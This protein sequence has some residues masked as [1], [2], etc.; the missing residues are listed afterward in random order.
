MK[1]LVKENPRTLALVSRE[2]VLVFRHFETKNKE[3]RCAIEFLPKGDI[4]LKHYKKLTDREIG[5]FLGFIEVNGDTF[6]CCINGS[7]RVAMPVP[8]E[9]INKIH[10]VDFYSVNNGT[11]D[12]VELD[13]NGFPIMPEQDST[14]GEYGSGS[15]GQYVKHPCQDLRKLLS[16]GG[17]YYSSDFDLTSSL[18]ARGVGSHS[19][20]MD[21]YKEEYMWNSFMLQEMVEFRNRLD[22]Q[23]KEKLDDEG[24]LTTVIRGF[25]K[26]VQTSVEHDKYAM[27]IISRQSWKRAG[28]R[29]NSR[30][31]D[32]EGYVA[33]FVET[34]VILFSKKIC[35]SYTQIRGSIP[36]FWEQDTALINPKVQITRSEEATHPVF[37]THFKRLLEEYNAINI[38]NLLS[39]K[40]SELPLSQR[41]RSHV[42]RMIDDGTSDLYMTDFD[43]HRE[44]SDKGFSSATKIYNLIKESLYEFGYF[45]YEVSS[46]KVLSEQSGSIINADYSK[47]SFWTKEVNKCLNQHDK[48]IMLRAEQMSSLMLL[49]FVRADSMEHIKRVEGANKKTGLGGITGNKG[50]VGIRFNYGSSS[51]CFVNVHLAAGTTNVQDRNNDYQSI[52]NSVKFTRNQTIHDNETV[53]WIGDLNYRIALTSDEV[54]R[55][56]EKGDFEYLMKYDQLTEEIR[57]NRAFAGYSEPSLNFNPTYKYD[58]GTSRYDSSEKF[59][60]P[61]WTDRIIYKSE[62]VKPLAYSSSDGVVFSDHKPVY[63]AYKAKVEFIDEEKKLKLSKDI[64]DK[65]K[66]IHVESSTISLVDLGNSQVDTK[67]HHTQ[68]NFLDADDDDEYK[69]KLPDRN[70]ALSPHISSEVLTPRR[71][72]PKPTP[73]P[74]RSGALPNTN[75]TAAL[76][77]RPPTSGSITASKTTLSPPPPPAPRSATPVDVKAVPISTKASPPPAPL[78]RKAL[79]PGFSESVLVP[80]SATPSR[81]GTPLPTLPTEKKTAPPSVPKKPLSLASQDTESKAQGSK[82]PPPLVPKKPQTL[83]QAPIIPK[84]PQALKSPSGAKESDDASVNTPSRTS[85]PVEHQNRGM[86][87]WQPLVP[88]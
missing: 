2:T 16:S 43:F 47:S 80:K 12:Y 17:F 15:N 64:Y 10:S 26:T 23:L 6:I 66:A 35:Y 78:P 31:V 75:S 82:S 36:V 24:F 41:Y 86:N 70:A 27:T 46:G 29:F 14:P 44:T 65:Y 22:Q 84:K 72:S 8:H 50:A 62:T 9:S 1:L 53:F 83:S 32:D 54:R 20:S 42:K 77:P 85:T 19:L 74:S 21:K 87:N 37:V 5:G 51:F 58:K 18:Q 52:L 56:I 69:P 3:S 48:Y 59:R 79:P 33:N 61:S 63:A 45:S 73:P 49:F 34:E 88:K 39:T 40:S 13:S 68:P 81:S 76:P 25:A 60:T 55:R 38:V 30:G 67:V 4:E 57:S 71:N 28:T 7:T 11:W